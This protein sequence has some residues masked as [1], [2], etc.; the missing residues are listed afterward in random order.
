MGILYWKMVM[1][2]DETLQKIAKELVIAVRKNVTI[3][4][5][6]K[7]MAKAKL[8]VLVRR[9][10]RKYGYRRINRRRRP[11]Q[12]CSMWSCCVREWAC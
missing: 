1:L 6:V 3:H 5:T 12:F 11:R 8:R 2:E 9:L 7:E 4:W 10:L